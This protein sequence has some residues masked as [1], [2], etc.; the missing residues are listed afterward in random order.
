MG[1][2]IPRQQVEQPAVGDPSLP[3]GAILWHGR[4]VGRIRPGKAS[5]RLEAWNAWLLLVTHIHTHCRVQ[6]IFNLQTDMTSMQGVSEASA[7]QV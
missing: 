5:A 4:V 2:P 7:A 1:G 3:L 6:K